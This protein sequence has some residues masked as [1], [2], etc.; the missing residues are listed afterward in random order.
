MP[1]LGSFLS[2]TQCKANA[3]LQC[4]V[5]NW[6]GYEIWHLSFKPRVHPGRV[7]FK[8]TW[9]EC[10]QRKLSEYHQVAAS[11]VGLFHQVEQPCD[12]NLTVLVFLDGSR[13]G[14]AD[15]KNPSH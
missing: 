6:S 1:P 8:V 9:E 15:T 13:L 10:G 14:R 2:I 11:T 12:N 5:K 7:F 3:L 4:E